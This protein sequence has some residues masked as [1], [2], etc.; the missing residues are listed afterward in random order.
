MAG[1]SSVETE[2]TTPDVG[3]LTTVAVKLG[4]KQPN[5]QE[6]KKHMYLEE[7]EKYSFF[8]GLGV[9]VES[10]QDDEIKTYGM[11]DAQRMAKNAV[12]SWNNI[13]KD[14][15]EMHHTG[16]KQS[17]RRQRSHQNHTHKP[18]QNK[19]SSKKR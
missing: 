14:S 16:R 15:E 4:K 19:P 7:E 3:F 11:L 1:M 10:I 2:N 8:K 6:D 12:E 18:T 9:D 13:P 5:K 17:V